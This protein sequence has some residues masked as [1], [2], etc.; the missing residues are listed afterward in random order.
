[1]KLTIRLTTSDPINV[2][3][4]SEIM[5]VLPQH[6]DSVDYYISTISSL[7]DNRIA[8]FFDGNI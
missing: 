5:S 4:E 6:L 1:M 2:E 7:L 8:T 3:A